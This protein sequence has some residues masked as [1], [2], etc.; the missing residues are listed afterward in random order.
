MRFT[1]P[2]RQPPNGA[3]STQI[4]YRSEIELRTNLPEALSHSMPAASRRRGVFGPTGTD[5]LFSRRTIPERDV[6]PHPPRIH[7][8]N[9]HGAALDFLPPSAM[10]PE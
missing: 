7:R 10:I 2:A 1:D 4:E 5:G 8:R 3:G 9:L 6:R